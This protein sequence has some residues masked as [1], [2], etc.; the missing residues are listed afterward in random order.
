MR[1]LLAVQANDHE[2]GID[3]R[4]DPGSCVTYMSIPLMLGL[5]GCGDVF[6]Y[7]IG[8]VRF[9]IAE[10]MV[11]RGLLAEMLMQVSCCIQY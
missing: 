11:W 1:R 10:A 8:G 6:N 7:R 3:P 4:R 5:C 9:E 2:I